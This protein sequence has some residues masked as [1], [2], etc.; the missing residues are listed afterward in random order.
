MHLQLACA[1][2]YAMLAMARAAATSCPGS[3]AIEPTHSKMWDAPVYNS[4]DNTLSFTVR[5]SSS[6]QTFSVSCAARCSRVAT[7]ETPQLPMLSLIK[8]SSAIVAH[9]NHGYVSEATVKKHLVDNAVDF[10][11]SNWTALALANPTCAF[12]GK[13]SMPGPTC[14]SW[15]PNNCISKFRAAGI[16]ADIYLL[17]EVDELTPLGRA[18]WIKVV[19]ALTGAEAAANTVFAGIESRYNAAVLAASKATQRPTVYAGMYWGTS[20]YPPGGD[21]YVANMLGDAAADY[22]L[23]KPINNKTGSLTL[24]W[25]AGMALGEDADF[26]INPDQYFASAENVVAAKANFSKWRS[27]RCNNIWERD[28]RKSGSANDALESGIVLPDLMLRDLIKIFH[29]ELQTSREHAFEYYRT[30]RPPQPT[31]SLAALTCTHPT[32][33]PTP[34]PT[35][36]PTSTT[37]QSATNAVNDDTDGNIG[38]ILTGWILAAIAIGAV[39]I[40]ALRSPA[41]KEKEI[42]HDLKTMNKD[43]LFAKVQA[44]KAGI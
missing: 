40:C 4:T 28:L 2:C 8:R 6:S 16:T 24:G 38:W 36:S 31:S 5:T 32:P 22:V 39:V 15:S 35:L 25:D 34:S 29:P 10:K 23:R 33:S 13:F 27:L 1:A 19:G 9:P 3:A 30:V 43:D 41:S 37:S 42:Y 18:E 20:W 12:V 21:S 44:K 17:N 7:F 11:N 26:W 14:S